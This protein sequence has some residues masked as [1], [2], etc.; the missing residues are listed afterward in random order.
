M[1]RNGHQPAARRQHGESRADVAQVRVQAAALH[2]GADGERRVHEHDRGRETGQAVG[3]GLGVVPVHGHV[4]KE[5]YQESRPRRRQFVEVEVPGG[6]LPQRAVR[7]DGQHAG[8]RRGFQYS[9]S[10]GRI[11]AAWTAA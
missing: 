10:E 6:A 2:A 8:A 7:H 5:P 9:W 11:A 4:G 1:G 3:D